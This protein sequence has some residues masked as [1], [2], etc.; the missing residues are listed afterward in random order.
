MLMKKL[1][2][3]LGVFSFLTVFAVSSSTVKWSGQ[4]ITPN[5]EVSSF[6][7]IRCTETGS[8]VITDSEGQYSGL[9]LK[10]NSQNTLHFTSSSGQS[11]G[12][13]VVTTSSS[14]SSDQAL[15]TEQ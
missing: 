4:L 12:S 7:E 8:S 5:Y 10:A 1:L 15:M 2:L 11:L 3:V 13:Q 6:S 14:D 9:I